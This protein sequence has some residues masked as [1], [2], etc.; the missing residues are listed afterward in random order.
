MTESA[1]Q[2]WGEVGEKFPS[3]GRRIADRYHQSGSTETA[4]ADEAERELKRAMKDLFDEL[5]RG[6]SAVG[7]TLKDDQA[8]QDLSEAVSALGD[9]ITAT[10]NEAT[11]AIRSKGGS[12]P[13]PP[14]PPPPPAPNV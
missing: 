5:S 1:K 6:V 3:F 10:V 2:S 14:P 11:E 8:K 4:D 12:T 9:T 13:P 7:G